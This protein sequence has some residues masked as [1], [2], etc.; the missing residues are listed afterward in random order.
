MQRLEGGFLGDV[1][2][3]ELRGFVQDVSRF[4][5]REIILGI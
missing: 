4:S 2:A 3:Y 5:P 1:E